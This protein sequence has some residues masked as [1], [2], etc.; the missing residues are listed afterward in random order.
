[1]KLLVSAAAV[2]AIAWLTAPW[3]AMRRR[4]TLDR[5]ALEALRREVVVPRPRRPPDNEG[6][7]PVLRSVSESGDLPSGY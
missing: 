4:G 5:C 3:V 1:M 2:A 7:S 6:R